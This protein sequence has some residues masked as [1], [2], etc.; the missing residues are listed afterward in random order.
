MYVIVEKENTCKKC[1]KSFSG[2]VLV[3]ME[4]EKYCPSCGIEV[5]QYHINVYKKLITGLK[6]K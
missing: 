6:S 4:T 5:L 1:N 3:K 2:K